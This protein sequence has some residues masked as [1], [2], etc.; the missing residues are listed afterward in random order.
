MLRGLG[1]LVG[2]QHLQRH[3]V[4][5]RGLH[6]VVGFLIGAKLDRHARHQDRV[7]CAHIFDLDAGR[8]REQLEQRQAFLLVG[9]RVDDERAFRFGRREQRRIEPGSRRGCAGRR[10]LGLGGRQPSDGMSARARPS[11]PADRVLFAKPL[12]PSS[13]GAGRAGAF[14][15]SPPAGVDADAASPAGRAA[16]R[17][18]GILLAFPPVGLRASEAYLRPDN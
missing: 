16:L 7:G 3:L 9:R 11:N 15:L 13:L 12:N 8:V 1:R 4:D 18:S 6:D 5:R 14:D 2:R 17:P 10:A